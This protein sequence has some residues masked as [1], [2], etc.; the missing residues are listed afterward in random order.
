MKA[1]RSPT[2][3]LLLLAVVFTVGLTF[4]TI[5]LPYRIDEVLQNTIPT[6]G[7]DS[8]VD[9]IARLKTELF[10][11]HYHVRAVG[12]AGFF[13]LVGL[14]V[15]GF[16]TRRTGLAALGAVGVMLP[17]FA[18]FAGVMFFLA[19]LGALNALWLPVLDVSYGLQDWGLV[20]KAPNDLLRWLLGLVGI[21]SVWPTIVF[22]VGSGILIFLLG[23]YAWLTARARGKGVA[24]LW[25]YRIS[26]HPQYLGWILW[27]YG[28]FL[29]IQ[30]FRYPK[31]S[32]GIGASLPW[33]I[34]TMVIIGVALIEE[35]NMRK[36]HGEAYEAYRRS[37]PFLFPV[38]K[39]LE[40]AFA[41][42][43]RWLFGKDRPDR[44]REVAV[45]VALYTAI[46]MGISAVFYAGALQGAKAR[47][48]SAETRREAVQQL[49]QE[50][51]D[52]PNARRQFHLMN[53]LADF[54][55]PAVAPLVGF[56]EG[57]D[58]GLRAGAAEVLGAL[59]S[60]RAV[61]ALCVALA[62][63]DSNLRYWAL[64][65]LKAIHAPQAMGPLRDRLEDSEAHI[66]IGAFQA[67]A[68]LGDSEILGI[69]PTLLED[70]SHW[71][72]GSIVDGLGALGSETALPLLEHRLSDEHE[73]VRR[74]AVLALLRIGSPAARSGLEGAL[75][76]E[77]FEVRVYAAE[78]LKRLP[79]G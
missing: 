59:G 29:L 31:R 3:S 19:G 5:E 14:I 62:D 52:E 32:W 6:P 39:W 44:R 35:L 15:A 21:H 63:P 24:D 61:P 2:F 75:S 43:F 78:A 76:D 25:V 10:M 47:F 56:L 4:A 77:D 40:R 46:L 38:P 64:E 18:Q 34:S 60:E 54:G 36:R 57:E 37:A 13:T 49:V 17:V 48:A 72:R 65:G 51:R 74:E 53:R 1:N 11:A 7:G 8:H 27:T 26:R 79:A 58:A 22:F 23:V 50:I 45:V 70:E 69:A 66:R 73:W 16:S 33:L 41:S 71:G 67:L 12:Y 30:L 20:I 42:P 55:E 28:A 68:E 9:D